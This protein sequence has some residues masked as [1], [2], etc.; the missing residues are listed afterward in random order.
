MEAVFSTILEDEQILRIT[1]G[2]I[3]ATVDTF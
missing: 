3:Q 2:T 1:E